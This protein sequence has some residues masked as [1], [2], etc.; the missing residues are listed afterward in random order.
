MV[1]LSICK[2]LPE[3]IHLYWCF[4]L[5]SGWCLEANHTSPHCLHGQRWSWRSPTR[6]KPPLFESE[7][8]AKSLFWTGWCEK[9][10]HLPIPVIDLISIHLI[11][12]VKPSRLW[13]CQ[14]PWAEK[15]TSWRPRFIV[16]R[17]RDSS[18]ESTEP[19]IV[20]YSLGHPEMHFFL[21]H[22]NVKTWNI[23]EFW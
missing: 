3:G 20:G 1:D 4:T 17:W 13:T 8:N 12:L 10:G 19:Q 6:K 5:K 21:N 15:N 18:L 11:G 9:F 7:R 22:W 14:D 2:R 23:L 16:E